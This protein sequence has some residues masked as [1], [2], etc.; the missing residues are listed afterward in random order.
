MV[1]ERPA[2]I[3]EES[4]FGGIDDT[5]EVEEPI[6]FDEYPIDE[7]ESRDPRLLKQPLDDEPTD[8]LEYVTEGHKLQA[9]MQGANQ[10]HLSQLIIL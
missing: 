3:A 5:L 4:A 8:E 7:F 9:L 1:Y 10:N 2:D 6:D